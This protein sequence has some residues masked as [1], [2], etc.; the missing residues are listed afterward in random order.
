[1]FS[2]ICC[3]SLLDTGHVYRPLPLVLLRNYPHV[4]K[5][6]SFFDV[7]SENQINRKSID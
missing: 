6:T 5:T 4:I 1:M 7:S 3:Y 2:C